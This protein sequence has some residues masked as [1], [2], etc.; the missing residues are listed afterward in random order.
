MHRTEGQYHSSNMFTD[1]PPGT[2][3][4]SNWANAVQE[5]IAYVI[6]QAGLSLLT[7]S[8]DT[9]QQLYAA[10]SQILAVK[11]NYYTDS[12]SANSIILTKVGAGTPTAYADGMIV[13]FIANSSSTGACTINVSGIGSKD[14][15]LVGGSSI[16]AYDIRATDFYTAVFD[17]SNDRFVLLRPNASDTRP[18]I[19][20]L[21]TD[22]EAIDKIHTKRAITPA[23]LSALDAST[24]FKGFAELATNGETQ[25]MSS[26][27]VVI[28]PQSLAAAAATIAT[29]DRLARYDGS[30][31]LACGDATDTDHCVNAGQFVKGSNYISFPIESGGNIYTWYFQWKTV[32]LP[33]NASTAFTWNFSFPVSCYGALIT[34]SSALDDYNEE[35]GVSYSGLSASGMTIQSSMATSALVFGWGR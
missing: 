32:S 25:A 5:E 18:G 3:V 24:T 15:T 33:N 34:R 20:E 13:S 26:A 16:G 1:G 12:G 28:T 23:N 7:A 10:I 9:R 11:Q 2:R 27:N 21:A 31:K 8:T 4:E 29:A 19:V 30:G 14:L 35:A 6:T 22:A 17:S